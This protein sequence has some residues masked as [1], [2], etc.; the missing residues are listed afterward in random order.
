MGAILYAIGDATQVPRSEPCVIAH[1]VNDVGAWGRGFTAPLESR[2]PGQAAIYRRWAR[3]QE[4]D[5]RGVPVPFGLGRIYVAHTQL[6]NV[7]VAHLCAQAGLPKASNP[8]PLDYD[9][10]DAAL[11]R[12]ALHILGRTSSVRVQ[13]PRIGAGLARGNWTKIAPLIEWH[14]GKVASVT[15]LDPPKPIP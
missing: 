4:F 7:D 8:H 15:V 12:L 1:I 14:L 9:A 11:G 6:P 2:Y 3:G 5:A 13:M 10:L